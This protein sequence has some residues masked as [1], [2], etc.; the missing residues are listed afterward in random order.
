MIPVVIKNCIDQKRIPVYGDGSNIRDWLYVED[1]CDAIDC[2]VSKGTLGEVYNI[3]G[4][5]EI[6]NIT[7]V[8][9]ICNLMD[10]YNPQNSPHENLIEF[11]QDRKGHDW[12][13]AIDNNKIRTELNWEPSK[14]F[15]R[16]FRNTIEFYLN[17]AKNGN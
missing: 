13:Y 3:G 16:M 11:V 17:E 2:I 9:K 7:L 6:D 12:R 4:I 15:N 10:D 5:N 14:D 8:K 1:H